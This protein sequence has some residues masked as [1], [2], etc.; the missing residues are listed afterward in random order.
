MGSL[1]YNFEALLDVREKYDTIQLV[2][3]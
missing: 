1:L 2:K 3:V